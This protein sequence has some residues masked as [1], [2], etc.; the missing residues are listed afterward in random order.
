M[1][2]PLAP[3]AREGNFQ[4]SRESLTS[5]SACSTF[6]SRQLWAEAFDDNGNY[7]NITTIVPWTRYDKVRDGRIA[8]VR[9]PE[10]PELLV[11]TRDFFALT[12]QGVLIH[13]NESLRDQPLTVVPWIAMINCDTNGTSYSQVDDIFT[14]TRDL[15]AQAAL[16]YSLTSEVNKASSHFLPSSDSP[17]TGPRALSRAGMSNQSGIPDFVRKGAR[18]VRDDFA[19]GIANHREPVHVRTIFLQHGG[20]QG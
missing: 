3:T 16:L 19:A 1:A 13:F 12:R 8:R 6:I 9:T 20:M 11:L 15:G 18:R 17:L 14:L 5:T 7:T 4:R 2:P 10:K